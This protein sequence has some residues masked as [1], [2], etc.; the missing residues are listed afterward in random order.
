MSLNLREQA[1]QLGRELCVLEVDTRNDWGDIPGTRDR[2]LRHQFHAFDIKNP[3]EILYG[4]RPIS[5]MVGPWTYDE[6]RDSEKIVVSEATDFSGYTG[7]LFTYEDSIRFFQTGLPSNTSSM[8]DT[9]YVYNY[10][11]FTMQY[12]H[13][14]EEDW[15]RASKALSAMINYTSTQLRDQLILYQLKKDFFD[16]VYGDQQTFTEKRLGVFVNNPHVSRATIESFWSDNVFGFQNFNNILYW[17]A[18]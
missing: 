12:S 16:T 5:E 14:A 4:Q 10:E 6:E 18:I 7:E 17:G 3:K 1:L 9:Y 15:M 11:T 13:R 2:D 8:N